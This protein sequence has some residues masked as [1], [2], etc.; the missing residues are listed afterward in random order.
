MEGVWV[1]ADGARTGC[2]VGGV[3][4]GL[5]CGGL[6]TCLFCAKLK[7]DSSTPQS[8]T[9]LKNLSESMH[10]DQGGVTV[11][12]GGLMAGHGGRWRVMVGDGGSFGG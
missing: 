6:Q 9:C 4:G 3:R 12:D 8:R 11:G 10:L 1:C 5:G 2:V 7:M